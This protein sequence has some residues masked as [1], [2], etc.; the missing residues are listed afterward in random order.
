MHA[1][2]FFFHCWYVGSLRDKRGKV[3]FSEPFIVPDLGFMRSWMVFEVLEAQIYKNDILPFHLK[4]HCDRLAVSARLAHINNDKHLAGNIESR[5]MVF[6]SDVF[7]HFHELSKYNIKECLV[8]IYLTKGKTKDGFYAASDNPTLYIFLSQKPKSSNAS[9]RLMSVNAHR[10]F[11]E[12]KTINYLFAEMWLAQKKHDTDILYAFHGA[13]TEGKFLLETSR[14]NFCTVKDGVIITCNKGV[15]A[16]TTLKIVKKLAKKEGIPL[17]EDYIKS[18]DLDSCTEAF[19][20]STTRGVV[21]VVQIDHIRFRIG[22]VAKKLQT[23]FQ[24]YRKTYFQ[25]RRVEKKHAGGKTE[26]PKI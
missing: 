12:I 3:G 1:E 5:V 22:P 17:R 18:S 10:E 25:Q 4:D 26:A 14:C 7:Q 2:E 20:T 19:T 6:F 9:L 8:W 11:P 23:A 15:L 21:P 16:G 24:Q 13:A